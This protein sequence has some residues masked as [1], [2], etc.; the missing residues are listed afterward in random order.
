MIVKGTDLSPGDVIQH[1]C[2]T[3]WRNVYE[4]VEK[5]YI[6]PGAW[7]LGCKVVEVASGATKEIHVGP[8]VP[9][10]VERKETV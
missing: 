8:T 4:V 2:E 3:G 9:H 1:P 10:T 5:P 6:S 7:S